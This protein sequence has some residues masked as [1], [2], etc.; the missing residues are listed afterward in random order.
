MDAGILLCCSGTRGMSRNPVPCSL[1]WTEDWCLAYPI[2]SFWGVGD[3]SGVFF[4]LFLCGYVEMGRPQNYP[5]AMW[6][7]GLFNFASLFLC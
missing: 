4:F 1:E 2:L 6:L 3:D 7:K 5:S